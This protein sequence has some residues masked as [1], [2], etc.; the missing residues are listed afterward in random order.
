ML[1]TKLLQVF[2]LLV[3]LVG[4]LFRGCSDGTCSK[5]G[6]SPTPRT[7]ATRHRERWALF[8]GEMRDLETI[9]HMTAPE[10][11]CRGS[12][13][14]KTRN[15]GG[16]PVTPPVIQRSFELDFLTLVSPQG[17]VMVRASARAAPEQASYTTRPS[18]GPRRRAG[19]RIGAAG[20]G[21]PCRGNPEL[22]ARALLTLEPIPR[23]RR[24]SEQPR[25]AADDRRCVSRAPRIGTSGAS[26]TA[27]TCR[28]GKRNCGTS[29]PK[30]SSKGNAIRGIPRVGDA[31]PHDV[32]VATR[33]SSP[34]ATARSARWPRRRSLIARLEC[35]IVG[36]A[37][38]CGGRNPI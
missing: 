36:R 10:R 32:R 28:T 30:R 24:P 22:S 13:A 35:R 26:S 8:R 29:S 16:P 33:F 1:K 14:A 37:G 27:D 17:K 4:G 9:V 6:S 12:R 11:G 15:V 34:T 5:T 31:L 2:A 23:A 19:R 18:A 20:S 3:L 25:H 38:V 21:R 7:G